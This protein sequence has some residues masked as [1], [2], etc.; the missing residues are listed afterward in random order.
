MLSVSAIFL[1]EEQSTNQEHSDR[2]D[3]ARTSFKVKMERLWSCL[4]ESTVFKFNMFLLLQGVTMPWFPDFQYYFSTSV[5]EISPSFITLSQLCTGFFVFFMPLI[6]QKFFKT[7]DY[8]RI[9][10]SSQLLY[11]TSSG[12]AILLS[13]RI[14][15]NLGIPDHLSYTLIF[16]ISESLERCLTL[17]PSYIIMAKIIPHGIEGTMMA[18]TNTLIQ[19]N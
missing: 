10:F 12:L 3:E 11:V 14:T 7:T 4:R 13:L 16:P 9:F 2:S 1:R 5:L 6:Y 8:K 17:M 18:I 15:T 19:L